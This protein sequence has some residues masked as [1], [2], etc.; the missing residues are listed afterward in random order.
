M[1]ML[2]LGDTVMSQQK[3]SASRLHLQ[4]DHMPHSLVPG[5]STGTVNGCIAFQAYGTHDASQAAAATYVCSRL[6][7]W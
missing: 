7:S 4:P 1:L 3:L 5:T 2:G 6:S